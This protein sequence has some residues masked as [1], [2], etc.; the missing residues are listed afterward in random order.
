MSRKFL[1]IPFLILMCRAALGQSD[2]IHLVV[3][4]Q[5]NPVN[6]TVSDTVKT[7]KKSPLFGDSVLSAGYLSGQSTPNAAFI[8][9]V[10]S[11]NTDFFFHY[12]FPWIHLVIDTNNPLLASV[13]ISRPFNTISY[14]SGSKT[15]AGGE[16]E[17]FDSISLVPAGEK[18]RFMGF[19]RGKQNWNAVIS[20]AFH[21]GPFFENG[22]GAGSAM[23]VD[24][25]AILI[26]RS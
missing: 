15:I 23:V 21:S 13:Y 16:G 22:S 25:I 14:N 10:V 8:D 9:T 12:Q 3:F 19:C 18:I 4:V 7:F 5:G 6:V 24:S 20:K 17:A 26:D 1:A 2:V 11:S